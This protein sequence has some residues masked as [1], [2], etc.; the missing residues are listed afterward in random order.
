MKIKFTYPQYAAMF[1]VSVP[2]LLF[3][4]WYSSFIEATFLIFWVVVI[5]G[6][7]C[8]ATYKAIRGRK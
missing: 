2:V 3:A 7:G 4:A 8:H 6:A 5:F 1:F